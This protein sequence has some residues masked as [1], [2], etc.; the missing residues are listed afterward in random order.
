[1]KKNPIRVTDIREGRG[2]GWWGLS[3]P[4]AT[5]CRSQGS[6]QDPQGPEVSSTH[7]RLDSL[8]LSRGPHREP[9]CLQGCNPGL[10]IQT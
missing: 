2:G 7:R 6:G 4:Q 8:G 3:L 5:L 10:D 9:R 1:M